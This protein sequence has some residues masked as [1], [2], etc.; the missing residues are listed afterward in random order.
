MTVNTDRQPARPGFGSPLIEELAAVVRFHRRR[1]GLTRV[2]LARLAGVGK[3][4]IFDLE[5]GKRTV[6]LDTVVKILAALNI[7][8]T[9]DS[10]LRGSYEQE[11][12]S[13]PVEEPPAG[14]GT[15]PTFRG[16]P[17]AG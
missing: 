8:L 9:W 1:A 2:E 14:S 17:C 15:A 7:R 10:P 13:S 16:D 11:T 12:G 6:R 3:T 4:V 5:H